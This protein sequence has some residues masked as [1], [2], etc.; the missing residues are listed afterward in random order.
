MI[1][2]DD[3]PGSRMELKYCEGCGALILRAASSAR[4]YCAHCQPLFS[5]MAPPAARPTQGEKR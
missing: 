1:L 3:P 2:P 4:I 5:Q